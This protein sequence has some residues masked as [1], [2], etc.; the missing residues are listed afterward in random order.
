MYSSS[1]TVYYYVMDLYA[2]KVYILNDRWKFSSFKTLTSPNYMIS[3]GN[4]LYMTGDKNIRKVDPD[5]K[6]LINYKPTGSTPL[7][8]GISYNPSNELIYIAARGLK[9]I[10]VFNLNLTLIRRLSTSPHYPYS[11]TESS[12]KLYLGT[13]GGIILVMQ[14]EKIIKQLNGCNGNSVWLT[15][16]SFD[17][18]GYMA[19]SCNNPTNTLY[20][21]YPNGSFTGKNLATSSYPRFIGFDSKGRFIQISEKQIRIYN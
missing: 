2:N 3:I 19:T 1:N 12:N 21:Y 11:I 7:Y 17:K 13:L 4:N 14:N 5:L 20:L 8:R 15:S 10:Q 18:T 9:E 16:I 6:I